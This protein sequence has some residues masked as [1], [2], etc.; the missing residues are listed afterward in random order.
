MLASLLWAAMGG[1]YHDSLE[2]HIP[3]A[4]ASISGPILSSRG[5]LPSEDGRLLT[6]ILSPEDDTCTHHCFVIKAYLLKIPKNAR[7]RSCP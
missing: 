2:L 3:G 4:K 1:T 6:N 7:S 5:H